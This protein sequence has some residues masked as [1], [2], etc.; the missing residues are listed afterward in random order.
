MAGR[1]VLVSGG[2]RGIGAALTRAHRERGD[3]VVVVDAEPLAPDE[4]LLD[5]RDREGWVRVVDEV[6]ARHGRIDVFHDNAGIV[7]AGT[8]VEM[9]GKHWDD[10]V[11]VDLLGAVNGVLAVYPLMRRQRG[12]HI[13]VMGSLAGII[14][15]P[16]MVPYCSVKAAVVTM[17]R[18]LRVE[19]S[20]YDVRVT[21]VCPAFVDT[22]LLDNINPELRPTGANRIGRRFITQLQGPPMSPDRLAKVVLR[23]LPRNPET[24]LAPMP[25]AHLAVLGERVAPRV[26]RRVSRLALARYRSMAEPHTEAGVSP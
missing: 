22:P 13:V 6:V 2:S 21:V 11:D 5:V 15:V 4:L 26:V 20:R 24:V 14:P 7:V 18:A 19:A 25:L 10:I 23:A 8:H 9:T 1:I 3:T 17:A 12:G 16:A